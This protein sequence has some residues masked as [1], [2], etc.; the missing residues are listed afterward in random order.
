LAV[1]SYAWARVGV[2][3]L[4]LTV[5]AVALLGVVSSAPALPLPPTV[6]I[7]PLT[8]LESATYGRNAA[9][10]ARITND[11]PKA[12]RGVVVSTPIP[13]TSGGAAAFVAATCAGTLSA[14]DYTCAIDRV[15]AGETLAF[16]FVWQVPGSGSSSDCPG[17]DPCM[18]SSA[19][20]TVDA[21][22][23]P[24]GPAA[25][26]L[27]S[28]SSDSSAGT[29]A[30]ST[31]TSPSSPTLAT[32]P[33]LGPGNPLSTSIC[34]PSL[35]A[36]VPGLVTSIDEVPKLPSDPG[37]SPETSVICIPSPLADCDVTP[38]VFSPKATFTF[39]LLNSSL[40][41]GE[42]IDEVYHDG[43]LVTTDRNADRY[44]ASIKV[45]RR[46]GITTVVVKSSTNGEW[47]FG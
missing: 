28:S 45:Q 42:V 8:G 41:P 2:A 4:A 1:V 46:K 13:A 5:V 10:V 33:A 26:S 12:L 11:N 24:A 16:T 21:V 31:C 43:V 35:P 19:T 27:L 34:A 6:S 14:T 30:T 40:P 23:Y 44:V 39:V 18:T 32:N 20:F 17:A 38:F 15:R 47:R 37:V 29:Y 22:G 25:T 3:V 36:G 7:D 9:F